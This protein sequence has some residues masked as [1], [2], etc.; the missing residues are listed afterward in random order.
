M[1][2]PVLEFNACCVHVSRGKMHQIASGSTL[3]VEPKHSG[4]RWELSNILSHQSKCSFRVLSSVGT[5]GK[6]LSA[7]FL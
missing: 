5:I 3:L 4:W 6:V 7:A 2:P 1:G